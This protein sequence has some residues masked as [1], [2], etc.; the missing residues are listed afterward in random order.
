MKKSLVCLLTIILILACV[1][2]LVACEHS[3][4]G[5]KSYSIN[6]TESEHGV[7]RPS[8]TSA[9]A[10]TIVTI[11]VMPDTG[12]EL[13]FLKIQANN[14][15][16]DLFN[17]NQ[18]VMPESDVTISAGFR[19]V[20]DEA[21]YNIFVT[22]GEHGTVTPSVT[23]AEAGELVEI[24]VKPDDGYAL[25]YL[26]V[27]SDAYDAGLEI[28]SARQFVMPEA[29]VV[30]VAFFQE[31]QRKYEI[32][33][34]ESDHGSV[35]PN[36]YQAAYND[37]ISFEVY[38]DD[39]YELK[40]LT[41]NGLDIT[42]TLSF[43]MPGCDVVIEAV[44]AERKIELAYSE[45]WEDGALVGYSVAGI[46]TVVDTDIVIPDTYNN[47]PVLEIE[48]MAFADNQ[49]I[50]SMVI[51]DNVR[52]L[53]G[54]A[55]S[56]CT[57][58]K[59][60]TIGKNYK[61]Y[62]MGYNFG[63][64]HSLEEI[65]YNAVEY[66][67]YDYFGFFKAGV[68]SDGVRINIGKDVTYIPSYMFRGY[69]NHNDQDCYANIVEVNF[70]ENGKCASISS[71]AFYRNN[72]LTCIEL[73]S[74][75]TS[76]GY[77]AFEYCINLASVT[78]KGDSRLKTIGQE[79]FYDCNELTN[80]DMPN[81]VTSIG[82][83]AFYN[84]NKLTSIEIN[85]GVT[86]IDSNAYLDCS[87][88]MIYCEVSSMPGEWNNYWNPSNRPV[89]WN[90]G[91]ER[92]ETQDGIKWALTN[93]N[94]I[95]IYGYSGT[96]AEVVIPT[97][98]G[99]H[100]VT[101]I[102]DLAFY[103]CGTLTSI[104]IPSGVISIG[105]SAF[106]NCQIE[107]ATMPI[108][109][110]DYI[111]K[112]RLKR[113]VLTSGESIGSEAFSNCDELISI[114]IPSSVTSIGADAFYNCSSLE[115]VY[116]NDNLTGWCGISFG[117]S[118][119]NPATCANK[120]YIDGEI[121]SGEL[122]IPNSITTIGN[123]AFSGCSSV[124]SIEIPNSVTSI[125]N[126]AFLGCANLESMTIPFVGATLDGTVNTHFGYLFGASEY[127]ENKNYVP[128][129]LKSVNITGG[130]SIDSDAFC[131][132]NSLTSIELP[133]SVTSIGS[134]AFQACSSL[135]SI[136]IPDGVT[137]IE[138]YTFSFCVKLKSIEMPSSLISIYD[139]AFY[140]CSSL[141]SIELPSG[142]TGIGSNA[143]ERCSSLTSIEIPSGVISIGSCAFQDCSSLTSLVIP[144]CV[145]RVGKDT[146][147][148]CS[149]L[150][151]IYCE[152]IREPSG[153]QTR[154][155]YDNK[156]VV[157]GY[158]NITT[159]SDYDYVVHN[160]KVYLTKYKGSSND[161]TIPETIE[162]MPVVSISTIFEGNSSLNSVVISSGVKIIGIN[163]F[164]NCISLTS[165]TY[166]NNSQLERIWD[167]AFY[168]CKVLTS[169]EI[170]SSVT[171]IAT[172][173]F[174]DCIGVESIT[175][176][177]D[178]AIYKSDGDCLIN[179]SDNTLVLGCKN[180]VIPNYI[181]RIGQNAFY[182]CSELTSIEIP[183]SVTSIGSE[184]FSDC[185]GLTSIEIP[186]TVTRIESSAFSVSNSLIIYSQLSGRL[187]DWSSSWK[188]SS[189]PV[190][191]NYGGERGETEDG[192]KWALINDNTIT[193]CGYKKSSTEVVIPA[194]ING[195]NVTAINEKAFYSISAGGNGILGIAG[196]KLTSI[197]IP[198]SVTSIGDS[199]FYNCKKLVSIYYGGSMSGWN[200]ISK[201]ND[202][203]HNTG[204][205]T[206]Y[207]S[208]HDHV[209]SEWI[210]DEAA[211]CVTNGSKHKECTICGTTIE[212]QVLVAI[213]HNYGEWIVTKATSCSAYGEETRYCSNDN[214]HFETR[215]I[216]KLAHTATEWI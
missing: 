84:C 152:A 209:A 107:E 158:N 80:I 216:E 104:D 164:K 78:F 120:L 59:S 153:W 45:I 157:W 93:S 132:C 179:M 70:A 98:I 162:G 39:G 55:F 142:V 76:I 58:L 190:V 96:P 136:N 2:G 52:K 203:D 108:I 166:G 172:D 208:I 61:D 214:S 81:S 205:Y 54:Y 147:S 151:I 33:V 65:N 74:S 133:D 174:Y 204:E 161:L 170:P 77:G 89:V 23:S 87:S 102:N 168:N 19:E 24:S 211:T 44:F 31:V 38:P 95:T 178:N 135:T 215:N 106:Y 56:D 139:S 47:L 125:G 72:F 165:V 16:V 122:T 180:S 195:H 124:T 9:T 198:V 188:S 138:R 121:L 109:S 111:P 160:D 187:S 12:F 118:Y 128:T 119:A 71:F 101:A 155:N 51:G 126:S 182:R 117:N 29:D 213:G 94:T 73:P 41:F 7:V 149:S 83:N 57:S 191:W 30:I 88:L 26:G 194:S 112:S 129:S 17:A 184:A 92:G 91:G 156:P 127:S 100:S 200:A 10:G 169:I 43:V 183:S 212:T 46:G 68:N 143:F 130:T 36:A 15:D 6:V 113:V 66:D 22:E 206:V 123:Y 27:Q 18:F 37:F 197:D 140:A 3:N 201:G 13:D 60:I 144:I 42:D 99:G 110:L 79:A 53:G 196:S 173:A 20:S 21:K 154:W 62:G 137:I 185:S 171:D 97:V 1:I 145:M 63:N 11:N 28:S 186:S 48:Y 105:S 115:E 49:K 167:N 131:Y 207:P 8:V 116:Y 177:S 148:S 67:E 202:W 192:I 189:I 134:A 50:T 141:T 175:V 35:V 14:G 4:I 114:E 85:S 150:T 32:N 103:N 75:V 181:I 146:I 193:I 25:A 64:L 69:W 159:D 163:A 34:K 5:G 210:I 86:K 90:Y 199:A 82:S 176:D 40:Q